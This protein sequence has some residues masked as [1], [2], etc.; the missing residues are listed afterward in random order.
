MSE[1]VTMAQMLL[2]VPVSPR[3]NH[4]IHGIVVMTILKG[5]GVQISSL[6]AHDIK[7]KQA[8]LNLN[9]LGEHL[10]NYIQ[11]GGVTQNA[12]YKQLNDFYNVF[13][14]SLAQA[15][16]IREHARLGGHHG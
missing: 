3:D 10:Q 2:P 12:Q 6:D 8:E 11:K 14:Q 1:S 7:L 4:L 15:V 5:L 16:N 9:H 13:K